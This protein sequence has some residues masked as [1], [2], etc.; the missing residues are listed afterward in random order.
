MD[1]QVLLEGKELLASLDYQDL[2]AVQEALV[3]LVLL[4]KKDP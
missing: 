3:G 2:P 4:D 1:H